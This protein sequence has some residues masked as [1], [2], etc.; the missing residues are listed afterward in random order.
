MKIIHLP[1]YIVFFFTIVITISTQAQ[2]TNCNFNWENLGIYG[3]NFSDIEFSKVSNRI[4]GGTTNFYGLYFTQ[5]SGDTWHRAYLKDSLMKDCATYGWGGPVYKVLANAKGWIATHNL[6]IQR[7][8][9]ALINFNDGDS[10]SWRA[11]A[12]SISLSSYG[13]KVGIVSDIYLSDYF[14]YASIDQLIT[15]TNKDTTI[16]IDVSSYSNYAPKSSILSLAASNSASGYPIY[17]VVDTNSLT[18]NLPSLQIGNGELFYKLLKDTLIQIPLHTADANTIA[19]LTKVFI[20]PFNDDTL[21]LNGLDSN[22]ARTIFIADTS[23][24]IFKDLFYG[25][26]FKIQL[27]KISYSNYWK[28]I[29]SNTI[30][31]SNDLKIQSVN[32]SNWLYKNYLQVYD[33]FED[34]L[35]LN[36]I[37]HDV[38]YV[39]GTNRGLNRNF[40]STDAVRKNTYL[41]NISVFNIN[42]GPNKAFYYLATSAGL[43]YTE[44]YNNNTILNTE[45]WKSPYGKFPV[46]VNHT[47][48]FSVVSINP[49]DTLNVIAG[50]KV[51]DDI[52]FTSGFSVTLNGV[53]GFTNVKPSGWGPQ[54]GTVLDIHFIDSTTIIAISGIYSHEMIYTDSASYIWQSSD[55]GLSWTNVTPSGFYYGHTAVSKLQTLD[56]TTVIYCGHMYA[57]E[58][59]TWESKDK[60]KNWNKTSNG[61]YGFTNSKYDNIPVM[62]VFQHPSIQDSLYLI[63]YKNGASALITSSD[64][65]SNYQAN[66]LT[67]LYYFIHLDASLDTLILAQPSLVSVYAISNDTLYDTDF[68]LLPGQELHDFEN[69]SILA[70]TSTGFYSINLEPID[71]IISKQHTLAQKVNY[72]KL[73]PNPTTNQGIQI[74]SLKNTAI[75]KVMVTDIMGRELFTQTFNASKIS[76]KLPEIKNSMYYIHISTENEYQIL[77]VTFI[78]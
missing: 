72:F 22:Q 24:L 17:L 37:Q 51:Y 38:Y 71:D 7:T 52:N 1:H 26:S 30:L 67:E 4:F 70:G 64:F 76:I 9:V 8:G 34:S 25:N 10:L 18:T 33:S 58:G 42:P 66:D 53:N 32:G 27:G 60:G 50:I 41:E 61:P 68:Y 46:H 14:A 23:T 74:I 47:N 55:K 39:Y 44:A 21:Y 65:G 49:Y 5:D 40:A 13:Y 56:T 20:S 36:G 11:F 15:M 6:G 62:D 57:T 48:G 75:K 73:F 16:V 69:G 31:Y 35:Y 78:E 54:S 45:K 12:D 63:G 19:Q 43:A 28:D 3:G 29:E 2:K 77:P 59:A